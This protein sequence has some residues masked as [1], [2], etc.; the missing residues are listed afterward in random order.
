M[1]ANISQNGQSYPV[2]WPQVLQT[3]RQTSGHWPPTRFDPR[4]LRT[5]HL[6]PLLRATVV[7]SADA[8]SRVFLGSHLPHEALLDRHKAPTLSSGS[9]IPSSLPPPPTLR[10]LMQRRVHTSIYRPASVVVTVVYPWRLRSAESDVGG[11]TCL[12]LGFLEQTM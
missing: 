9:L 8:A 5:L 4:F 10:D 6:P 3:S 12:C 2:S 11:R 7:P 1:F